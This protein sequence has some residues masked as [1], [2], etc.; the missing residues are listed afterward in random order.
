MTEKHKKILQIEERINNAFDDAKRKVEEISRRKYD[1][2]YYSDQDEEWQQDHRHD[3]EVSK[4]E[5]MERW[6]QRMGDALAMREA[7]KGFRIDGQG[8]Y[9]ASDF[10]KLVGMRAFDTNCITVEFAQEIINKNIEGYAEPFLCGWEV[11]KI[12]EV[13]ALDKKSAIVQIA[14]AT[15]WSVAEKMDGW[16][17]KLMIMAETHKLKNDFCEKKVKNKKLL[18]DKQLKDLLKGK[19]IVVYKDTFKNWKL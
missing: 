6:V 7:V 12:K 1:S 9:A 3:F 2:G 4:Q 14:N 8:L 11:A 13:S 15:S 10:G 18:T 16:Y 17:D 5:D 19:D